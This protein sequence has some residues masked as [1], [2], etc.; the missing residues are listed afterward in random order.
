MQINR[1]LMCFLTFAFAIQSSNAFDLKG[2]AQS[3]FNYSEDNSHIPAIVGATAIAGG[4]VYA[5]NRYNAYKTRTYLKSQNESLQANKKLLQS[6]IEIVQKNFTAFCQL[7][8]LY[9][10]LEFGSNTLYLSQLDP[11]KFIAHK[12]K[13]A[14]IP[15]GHIDE[16]GFEL[17]YLNEQISEFRLE[18]KHT[19][20]DIKSYALLTDL[21]NLFCHIYNRHMHSLSFATQGFSD[22]SIIKAIVSEYCPN[23]SFLFLQ[24]AILLDQDIYALTSILE[25]AESSAHIKDDCAIFYVKINGALVLLKNMSIL[26]KQTAQYSR[27]LA[28]HE[29]IK[30]LES[31][32]AS[33]KKQLSH[34]RSEIS[35]LRA[36]ICWL[37]LEVS[38]YKRNCKSCC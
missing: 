8:E 6:N 18:Y 19:I 16:F 26:I 23:E 22:E 7:P 13:L 3:A 15:A 33:L 28:T 34:A 27:D 31:E 2:F 25:K 30:S 9:E 35:S 1:F 38:S 5:H 32:I 12:M 24:T 14:T 36:R 4:L 37:E 17:N 11:I 10:T 29:H 20:N 21:H